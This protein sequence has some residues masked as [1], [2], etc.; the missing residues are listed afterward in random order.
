MAI[1][2][3]PAEPFL[4]RGGALVLAPGTRVDAF[5]DA[6]AAPGS[7]SSILLHDGKEARPIG[8]LVTS[9]EPPVRAAPLP[10]A[11]PLPSNGLP[12]RLD[13]KSALRVD[14]ALGGPPGDWVAPA[15]FA[16]TAAPAFRA[17]AGRIVVLALTNRAADRDR[18]P[19]P[20]PSF[21]P[22]RPPRRWLEAVLAGY[23]GNRSRADPADRLCRRIRRSL[24]D[25]TGRD[26]LGGAAPRAVVQCRVRKP[27]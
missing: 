18:V 9:G 2:G 5:V 7:T 27:A 3:Q 19:S 21:P 16:A 4:A 12:A 25:R 1:D 14:L 10:A 8:R 26:R 24:A 23:A 6:T 20:W 11:A 13:L 22:A 17:K 15:S